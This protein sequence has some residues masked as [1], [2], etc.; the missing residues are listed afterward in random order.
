VQASLQEVNM[1]QVIG[2]NGADPAL[3]ASNTQ[4]AKID[5][6]D[7]NDYLIGKA[8]DDLLIGG[9]GSDV[10][11]GGRGADTFAF[12]KFAAEGDVDYV[13]DFKREEGDELSFTSDVKITSASYVKGTIQE[14]NGVDLFNDAKAL[15]VVLTIEITDGTKVFEQQIYLVDALK[16]TTWDL[17]SFEDYLEG[18]GYTGGIEPLA[19]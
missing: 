5:G 13:T 15:D 7:G 16:N 6:K 9:K 2:T 11:H 19:A 10:M 3:R 17:A 14:F 12:S 4:D 18:L 8:G 1:Q